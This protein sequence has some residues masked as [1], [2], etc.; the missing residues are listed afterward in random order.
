MGAPP[1]A[2]DQT[3]STTAPKTWK[4]RFAGGLRSGSADKSKD[5]STISEDTSL[6]A[7]S[8]ASVEGE[9]TIAKS[10]RFKKKM[11][12]RFRHLLPSSTKPPRDASAA[13]DSSPSNP[14]SPLS[15]SDETHARGHPNG[16][17]VDVSGCS[18]SRNKIQTTAPWMMG[19]R[20]DCVALSF[21]VNVLGSQALTHLFFAANHAKSPRQLCLNGKMPLKNAVTLKSFNKRRSKRNEM[22]FVAPWTRMTDLCL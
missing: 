5:V 16:A 15:A 12:G 19:C 8:K 3:M 11:S 13:S 2:I 6:T 21:D 9:G 18:S 10:F 20:C 22:D 4:S 1:T 17:A 14:Q 7:A